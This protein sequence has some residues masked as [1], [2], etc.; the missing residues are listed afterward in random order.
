MLAEVVL[1]FAGTTEAL[2]AVEL[3]AEV[4]AVVVTE[5]VTQENEVVFEEFVAAPRTSLIKQ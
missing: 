3:E 2:A 5:V 1:Q 4:V